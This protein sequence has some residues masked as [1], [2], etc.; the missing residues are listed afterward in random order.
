MIGRKWL[1]LQNGTPQNSFAVTQSKSFPL[2]LSFTVWSS[3]P[4]LSFSGPLFP[5]S[6]PVPPFLCYTLLWL[7][8]SGDGEKRA[9]ESSRQREDCLSLGIIC[10][11]IGSVCHCVH[12]LTFFS[13]SGSLKVSR[14]F[15]TCSERRR[16]M[17]RASMARPR[18]SS[19]SSSGFRFSC[20]FL[21]MKCLNNT[22]WD[23][24]TL[25]PQDIWKGS[26]HSTAA[27]LF[28]TLHRKTLTRGANSL[29]TR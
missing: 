11:C 13:R 19:T 20:V 10:L 18:N 4:P 22:R 23:Q 3:L 21:K 24:V 27:T 28:S 2:S 25:T 12:V 29:F 7:T 8:S 16:S 17:L 9:A 14:N 1:E 6:N 26:S 15:L 5:L